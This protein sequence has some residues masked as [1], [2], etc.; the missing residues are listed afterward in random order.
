[1]A[2]NEKR[3]NYHKALKNKKIPILTLDVRWHEIFTEEN[4]TP[5]LR[6]LE[7]R[8]NQLLKQQG[9]LVNDIK[10]MKK[11]KNNL[12]KDIMVNMDIGNDLIGKAK[13]K[14]LDKNKQY[15]QE[16]NEKINKAMDDLA[17]IPYQIKEINDELMAESI[18]ICYERIAKNNDELS[19]VTKWI[20]DIREELKAKILVKQDMEAR[21]NVMYTYMHDIL[22]AELMESFDQTHNL[23]PPS[24]KDG[25]NGTK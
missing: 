4:K 5:M 19:K 15:I 11:L 18:L 22:G 13:E 6:E 1:M 9:K 16:L 12:I 10:D 25:K 23:I 2:Y 17:D 24:R 8:V 3:T 21:N 14:K 7:Q 20:A